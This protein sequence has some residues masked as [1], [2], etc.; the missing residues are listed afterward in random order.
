MEIGNHKDTVFHYI[1][2]KDNPADLVS[3]A[4]CINELLENKLWW[5]GPER[6]LQSTRVW[7]VWNENNSNQ[8]TKG[9]AVM[10]E[11]KLFAGEDNLRTAQITSPDNGPFG[12]N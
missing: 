7:R 8:D 9:P 12:M 11:A 1:P 4:T 3:R 2:S 6:L 10:Y 5:H